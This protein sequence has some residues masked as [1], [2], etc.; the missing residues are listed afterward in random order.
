VFYVNKALNL[1]K[2]FAF[3]RV[4]DK[5]ERL[6]PYS[7]EDNTMMAVATPDTATLTLRDMSL[8]TGKKV[9]LHR[10]MYKYGPGNG[11]LMILPIDQGLEHGPVDFFENPASEDP[12]FQFDLAVKGRYSAIALHYGLAQKYYHK[13]AGRVPLVLKL[14]GKTCVPPDDNAFSTLTGTVEDAVRLGADAVGY[15]LFVGSPSQDRDIA[16]F[17]EVR[18]EAERF[19]MP[20][21]M[22]AYPRGSYVDQK[23]GKNSLYAVDYAARVACELGADVVKVNYPE[24]HDSKRGQYPSPYNEMT[25]S[26]EEA[27]R[28]VVKSAGKTLVIFSG[29]SKVGESELIQSVR[30]GL[31]AGAVGLIFGRNMWQRPM[32][33]ALAVSQQVHSVMGE[34]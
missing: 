28:K 32:D 21:I 3:G 12:E 23:G 2:D 34:Y 7:C 29:G 15:T 16:Q 27:A 18:R 31:N 13:Y 1:V 5:S 14:N 6:P 25:L 22:W 24:T 8:C 17:Q 4:Y 10:M 19:G 9:R 33:E 11:K 30:T 20:I 26:A